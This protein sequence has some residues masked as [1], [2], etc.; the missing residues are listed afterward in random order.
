MDARGLSR[1]MSHPAIASEPP[2]FVGRTEAA[3]IVGVS[4]ATLRRWERELPPE[5]VPDV[6]A[7]RL[8]TKTRP[9]G[10]HLHEVPAL[11]RLMMALAKAPRPVVRRSP[12]DRDADAL[13]I[14]E[15]GGSVARVVRDCRITAAEA[16]KLY[17]LWRDGEPGG[18]LVPRALAQELTAAL[19]TASADPAQWVATAHALRGTMR[20]TRAR[21]RST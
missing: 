16:S 7:S 18:T 1:A 14:F 5:L 13:S 10:S 2:A 11:R 12:A 4:V 19:G 9:D 17:R 21:P 15:N 8:P 20:A 3:R 6:G